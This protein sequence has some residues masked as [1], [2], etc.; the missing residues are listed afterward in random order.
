M[1][2]EGAGDREFLIN[3]LIHSNKLVYLQQVTGLI[4]RNS[5]LKSHG[6]D[7]LNF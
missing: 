7:F 3:L 1:T 6:Q 4:Y 2:H 5:L